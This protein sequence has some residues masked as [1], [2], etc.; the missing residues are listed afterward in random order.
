MPLTC[1]KTGTPRLKGPAYMRS[2]RASPWST[3]RLITTSWSLR[4]PCTTPSTPGVRPRFRHH[5]QR[6]LSMTLVRDGFIAI[7][8]GPAPGFDHADLYRDG[9]GAARLYVAHTGA[10]QVEVIDCNA[11]ALA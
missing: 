1:P 7:P 8:P 4:R 3:A 10:D 2:P 11:R 6:Q 5:D 9:S